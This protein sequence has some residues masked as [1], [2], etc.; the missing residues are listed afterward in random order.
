ML[1]KLICCPLFDELSTLSYVLRYALR[2]RLKD[3]F[4][5]GAPS[6]SEM[7]GDRNTRVRDCCQQFLGSVVKSTAEDALSS[8]LDQVLG[9]DAPKHIAFIEVLKK[10]IRAKEYEQTSRGLLR[11]DLQVIKNAW[12][13]YADQRRHR[14]ELKSIDGYSSSLG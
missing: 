3:E 8:A 4:E 1:G 6:Q 7:V 14:H 10:N 13:E 5:G 12:K 11:S 9:R 2:L